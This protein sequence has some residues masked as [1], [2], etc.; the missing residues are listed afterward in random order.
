MA[1]DAHRARHRSGSASALH[2]P[3]A[4]KPFFHQFRAAFPDIRI[5]VEDALVDGDRIAVRCAVTATHT[6]PGMTPAPTNKAARFTGMCIARVKDGKIVEG[7]NNFDFLSMYQQ[8]GM[9][10]ELGE[11]HTC[12]GPIGVNVSARVLAGDRMHPSGIGVRSDLGAHRRGAGVRGRHVRR[13]DRVVHRA[14]RARPDRADAERVRRAGVSHQ[15]R[16]QAAAAG[17]CGPWLRQRAERDAHGAG[18]G[19][20]RRRGDVHR[21]HAAA[22]R[23]MARRS[24]A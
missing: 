10:A 1:D 8:L 9:T 17:R 23:P 7:W 22:A 18:T 11:R 13:L 3:A 16:G 19:D 15:P 5:T 6:G 20:R 14:G 12:T 24:R 21:G 4:F 2:G